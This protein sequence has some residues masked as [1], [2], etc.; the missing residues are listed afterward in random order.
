MPTTTKA[1]VPAGDAWTL[2]YAAAG[3][4]TISLQNQSPFG[5]LLVR[6]GANAASDDTPDSAAEVLYQRERVSITLATDDYVFCRTLS[7]DC[8]GLVVMRA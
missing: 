7:S 1:A 4:V 5:D 6:V 2:I 3:D 8:D